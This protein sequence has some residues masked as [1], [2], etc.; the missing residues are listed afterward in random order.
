MGQPKRIDISLLDDVL[1]GLINASAKIFPISYDDVVANSNTNNYEYVRVISDG[2][3]KN[4][5]YIWNETTWVLIGADDK[6][7]EWDDVTLKPI[8]YPPDTHSHIKSEITDFEHDHVKNDITDFEHE[9]VKDDITDFAHEHIIGDVNGLQ[10]A[11]DGKSSTTHDH[12]GRYNTKSEITSLLLGKSDTTHVHDYASSIHDHDDDYAVK[13]IE[14]TVSNH[15]TRLY[16]IE[17]GYSEGHFHSN[18]SVLSSLTQLLVDAWNSAVTHVSDTIKHI[19]SEERTLWNTVSNKSDSTHN[20]DDRYYTETEV[21]TA[22]ANKVN[23][24]TFNG[25]TGSSTIHVTQTDKDNWNS[26]TQITLSTTKPSTGY[27]FKEI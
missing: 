6:K 19:T 16:N 4:E 26:K 21:D 17:G 25:H 27:W 12:D 3:H 1:R 24:T 7:I 11:L 18:L 8:V 23:T 20:H 13:S 10:T 9:H 2:E 14:T 5:I 22:L 15:E